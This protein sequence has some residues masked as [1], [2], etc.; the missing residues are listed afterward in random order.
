LKISQ[1][2]SLTLKICFTTDSLHASGGIGFKWYDKQLPKI[3]NS[4]TTLCW[5]C[6]CFLSADRSTIWYSSDTRNSWHIWNSNWYTCWRSQQCSWVNFGLQ[7]HVASFCLKPALVSQYD[8]SC[9]LVYI[10]RNVLEF[11]LFDKLLLLRMRICNWA[12]SCEYTVS[13]KTCDYMSLTISWTLCIHNHFWHTY[14]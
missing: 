10:F 13:Y 3:H 4:C 8:M 7:L 12:T 1:A 6:C 14:D 2:L 9:F 5:K 11:S